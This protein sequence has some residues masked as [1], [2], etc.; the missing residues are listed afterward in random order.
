M[1]LLTLNAHSYMEKN[2]EMKLGSLVLA[3][4][5][6]KFDVIALQEVN[7]LSS[8]LPIAENRLKSSGFISADN[9]LIKNGNFAFILAEK[10]KKLGLNYNWSWVS[11]HIGYDIYDEGVAIFSLKNVKS[12]N[13][14][15]ISKDHSKENYKTRKVLGAEVLDKNNESSWFYSLHMGW[16]N[17]TEEPFKEQWERLCNNLK[18]QMNKNVY[19]MGDFNSPDSNENEGYNLILKNG[20]W[21]DTRDLALH[22]DEGSTIV[23]SIDG[24]E[25]STPKS[26]RVDYI[27]KNNSDPI[28]TSRVIF[29][30]QNY[31]VVSDHFGVS[32]KE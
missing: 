4:W 25:E 1:K 15:F 16:W 2:F 20:S 13:S 3:I 21:F 32:V 14:F 31:P 24:W 12:V 30:G 6:E 19:L 5:R 18:P 10:L 28:S 27:F 8:K 26:M 9:S 11:S 23:S 7:Q 17:D 22:K 29:N